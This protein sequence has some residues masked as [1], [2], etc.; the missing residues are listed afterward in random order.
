M[1]A[2]CAF[3]Q[4][5]GL[6]DCLLAGLPVRLS[7]CLSVRVFGCCGAM[8]C[9]VSFCADVCCVVVGCVVLLCVV[10]CSLLLC[11]SALLYLLVCLTACLLVCLSVC[12]LLCVYLLWL[13]VLCGFVLC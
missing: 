12:L 7:V 2:Y 11:F 4:R 3:C 13:Y 6:L 9:V 10:R 5:V 1:L 8:R